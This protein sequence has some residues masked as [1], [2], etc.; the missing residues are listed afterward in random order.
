MAQNETRAETYTCAACG[1]A[2]EKGWSDD[3]AQAEAGG[4][5]PGLSINDMAIVCDDCYPKIMG[6]NGDHRHGR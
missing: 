3:E 4:L 5:F 1:G 6:A 2:F